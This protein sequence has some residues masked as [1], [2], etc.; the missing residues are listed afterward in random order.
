MVIILFYGVVFFISY[1]ELI[2]MYMNLQMARNKIDSEFWKPCLSLQSPPELPRFTSFMSFHL[3]PFLYSSWIPSL[4]FLKS[5]MRIRLILSIDVALRWDAKENFLT[6]LV[7]HGQRFSRMLHVVVFCRKLSKIWW[8]NYQLSEN[9]LITTVDLIELLQSSNRKSYN[10]LP[11]L[12][13]IVHL[14]L[15]KN[16]QIVQSSLFRSVYI[17]DC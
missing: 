13:L 3:S 17:Y 11:A 16:L 9:L 12:Y 10:E 8:K 7:M 5:S 4:S 1:L 15:S 14:L 2:L 6:G